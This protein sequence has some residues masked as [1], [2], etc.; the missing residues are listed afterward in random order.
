MNAWCQD[1]ALDDYGGNQ[2]L[3]E[4]SLLIDAFYWSRFTKKKVIWYGNDKQL[5]MKSSTWIL[6]LNAFDWNDLFNSGL[7]TVNCNVCYRNSIF[8][9][10]NF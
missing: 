6:G 1:G 3:N 8:S 7:V 9:Y 5:S 4:A 2:L 10:A